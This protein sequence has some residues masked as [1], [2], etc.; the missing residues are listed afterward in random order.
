[1]QTNAD[2]VVIGAGLAGLVAAATAA[3]PDRGTRPRVVVIEGAQPGGRARTDERNGF[4][5]NQGPH[6]VY[7]EGAGR[8]VMLD[9]GIDP[10]GGPPALKHTFLVE[11]GDLYPMPASPTKLMASK[12]LNARGKAQIAKLLAGFG[13]IDAASLAAMSASQWLD[14]LE[15]QPE[16]RQLISMLLRTATYVDP[17]EMPISADA[18][19]PQMQMAIASGVRYIDGGWQTMV[20]ALLEVCSVRDVAVERKTTA[21]SVCEVDGQVEVVTSAGPI[22][23][24]AA[25]VASGGPAAA[26]GLLG[27]DPW[28][29]LGA[30]V[31]AACLDLGLTRPPERPV[32]F[33]FSE[34]LYLS[35]HCPPADPA[36]DGGAVVHLMRYGARDAATD[37]STLDRLAVAA[38]IDRSSIV[39]ERF[40]A[41][42]HVAWTVPTVEAGGLSGRPTESVPRRDRLFVAG[43][44][45]GPVGLLS[46]ASIASGAA[47]AAAARACVAPL[48]A[49]R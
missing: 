42:M 5:L 46:D 40:L 18:A 12:L 3:G 49:A 1:M 43:D 27:D 28:G 34:P 4:K 33:G 37:R 35:T 36:P 21:L 10:T 22:L 8:K 11:D 7:L 13:R 45:V 24:S 6:A 25:I 14:S 16:A 9:L 19:V 20:D 30:P 39:E 41:H 44:W 47:A 48:A 15:L 32:V 38:G 26:V 31:T 23:T 17:D 2:I 29:D